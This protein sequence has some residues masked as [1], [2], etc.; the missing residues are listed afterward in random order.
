MVNILKHL[1][2]D[3]SGMTYPWIYVGMLCTAFGWHY[4]DHYAYSVNYNHLG[5][6][7]Q[8]YGIPGLVA[9]DAEAAMKEELGGHFE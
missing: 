9:H 4:E 7:K 3:I 1:G 6:T 8:W 5:D 2:R